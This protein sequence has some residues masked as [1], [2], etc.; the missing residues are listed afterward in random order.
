VVARSSDGARSFSAPVVV[1]RF[2]DRHF[3]L[4]ATPVVGPEGWLRVAFLAFLQVG[5]KERYSLVVATSYDGGVTFPS[6]R[7]AVPFVAGVP[8]RLPHGTFRNL[9][10]PALAVSPRTGALVIAWADERHGDAD[11][12]KTSSNDRGQT[13]AIPARVNHDRL[14]DRKDQFQPQLAVSPSGTFACSWFDR[15]YGPGDRLIDVMVAVSR[16]D[17]RTFG[18]NLRVTPRSWDP[19]IG[20]P[21]V[22]GRSHDTFIGDYQGLVMDDLTIHPVWNDTQNGRSQQIRTASVP[23]SLRPLPGR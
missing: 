14:Y 18:A 10:L 17:A 3:A 20:A 11:I 9:S 5:K 16:D 12:M 21:H 23:V 19:A 1:E 8:D 15:R 22:N 13:W 6:L 4:G 2:D 7:T